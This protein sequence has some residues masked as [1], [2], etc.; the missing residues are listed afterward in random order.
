MK[1]TFSP[2]T[3]T[4]GKQDLY[5]FT[6]GEKKCY[7]LTN[8]L[9]GFSS[10]TAI[11]SAARHDH[12]LFMAAKTAPN[13]RMHFVTNIIEELA[14]DDKRF[15]TPLSS[16]QYAMRTAS[17]FGGDKLHSFSFRK[18]PKWTYQVGGIE[19]IKDICMVHHKNLVAVHYKIYNHANET[20]TLKLKPM[21]R[22]TN[23]E[24]MPTSAN[25][26]TY[27]NNSVTNTTTQTSCYFESNGIISTS[28]PEFKK[29]LYFEYDA[30]DGRDCIGSAFIP[31]TINCKIS[32]P[33]HEFF[34]IFSD[35]QFSRDIDTDYIS[36]LFD[37]EV[38]RLYD[39]VFKSGLT[40]PVAQSLVLAAD[41]FITN[42][43]STQGK[44]IIAG[45]TWFG[46]WGRDTMIALLGC[47]LST[48]RFEDAKSMLRTFMKY[49]KNGLL[50]NIFPEKEDEDL[51]YNTVDAALL[52][53]DAIYQTYMRDKDL[54]FV[55]EMFDTMTHIITCY[56][57]GTDYHIYM[58][59]DGLIS[60]GDDLE[61]LTW[62][63]IRFDDILPTPRHGKPVEIQAY[64][65]NALR[66]M[67]FFADLLNKD[68]KDYLTLAEEKVKPNFLNLFWNEELNCLRD[69]I[70]NSPADNQI[71][72][73][74]VWTLS[75]PFTMVDTTMARKILAVI[76]KEL[77]TPFGLR[78]L[79]MNDKEYIG[80]YGGSHFNRDM[81]YHQGT[82][83]AFPLGA[84]YLAS[85]KY[86][87]A[88]M[89]AT[90]LR[91]LDNTVQ[92]LFEGCLGQIAEIYDGTNPSKSQG[93]IAQAWSVGEILRAFET[94]IPN[95]M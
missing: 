28:N 62:M 63:D 18:F 88:F 58:D 42:R 36:D 73:N 61:Q 38:R 48:K 37:S 77:Y 35:T 56:R 3:F 16:Q 24:I 34:V 8:G 41:K 57:E 67:D 85:H 9:G 21:F 75:M 40:N 78:S 81:A 93:C 89:M 60:A 13:H 50:P 44:T 22:L 31:A 45:Y 65:Y 79:S 86:A 47:A 11:S 17:Q 69:V 84:Y 74:Q 2:L 5:D 14:Y 26:F 72:P 94:I 29:D 19:I 76:T 71:R 52:F 7:L 91:Q 95:N 43:D 20:A 23:R 32:K 10:L 30:R 46:D 55:D 59:K 12:A 6:H 1:N 53:I 68:K 49:E 90:L 15:S 66:I 64:W 54:I 27:T 39:L 25:D 4:V 83:W 70:S 87:D 51:R 80:E 33:Y 92:V 82:V